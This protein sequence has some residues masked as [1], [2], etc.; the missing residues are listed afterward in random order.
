M[1]V[2]HPVQ[3][4]ILREGREAILEGRYILYPPNPT[5]EVALI[6]EEAREEHEGQDEGN[7]GYG[8]RLGVF[9]YASNQKSQRHA[10][11]VHE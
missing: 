4:L 5:R 8:H 1:D 7:S 10:A 2:T 3:D 9:N 6:L 11:E